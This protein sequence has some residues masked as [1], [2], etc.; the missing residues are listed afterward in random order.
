MSEREWESGKPPV[1][2]ESAEWD[3]NKQHP[4]RSPSGDGNAIPQ[5]RLHDGSRGRFTCGRRSVAIAIIP[6]RER[7]R[8]ADL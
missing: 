7:T 2:T 5:R 3:A 1:L 8:T 6:L 4:G